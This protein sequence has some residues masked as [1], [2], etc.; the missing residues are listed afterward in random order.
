MNGGIDWPEYEDLKPKIQDLTL[1][2]FNT[3]SQKWSRTSFLSRQITSHSLSILTFNTWFQEH[4]WELRHQAL[5]RIIQ[6]CDADVIVLQEVNEQLLQQIHDN[7]FVRR[8][9]QYVRAPFKKNSIPTH[10]LLLLSKLP[11]HEA[12]LYPLPSNMGRSLLLVKT[13]INHED[14]LIATVHLESMN[15]SETRAKQLTAVFDL[16]NVDCHVILAGDFNFCSSV[17]EENNRL[18]SKYLDVWSALKSSQSGYT[19]DTDVNKM[20]HIAK[21]TKKQVRIDRVLLR[22]HA[23]SYWQAKS[24]ELLG[25]SPVTTKHS[26]IYPSDHFGL[27]AKFL[28]TK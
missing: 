7:D 11:L 1:N 16:L 18:D 2:Q 28:F 9:Y 23:S 4:Y 8:Q 24:I 6:D 21:Q 26:K 25:T 15:H 22:S 17:R 5:L 20:L 19:Q 12:T 27:L 14:F 3:K 13:R 10:G